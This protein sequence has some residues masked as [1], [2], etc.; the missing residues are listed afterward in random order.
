MRP[1]GTRPLTSGS[2]ESTRWSLGKV[3]RW[4]YSLV[5]G[6][7][8]TALLALTATGLAGALWPD[9][10]LVNHFRPFLFAAALAGILGALF[11][12]PSWRSPLAV[13][14]AVSLVVQGAFLLPTYAARA[15]YAAAVEGQPLSLVT[16]NLHYINPDMGPTVDYL[17]RVEP[18]FVFLQ[19]VAPAALAQLHDGLSDLL[20]HGVHCVERRYCNL[21]I[22]SR[23]PLTGASASYLGWRAKPVATDLALGN[24]RLAVDE[25]PD[26]ERAAAGLSVAA[27]LGGPQPLRLLNV[28]LTWPY[29]AAMQRR[30]FRW[31]ADR[32]ADLPEG[33][34]VLAGDF[35]ATPWSYGLSGFDAS[36]A[37]ERITRGQYSWPTESRFPMPLVPIDQVY[38]S[39]ELALREVVRGPYVGSDHY[40]I[41]AHLVLPARASQE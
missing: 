14:G 8:L 6:L 35:N 36:V 15:S 13:L 2:Q 25:L 29:P 22:L 20:P 9:L 16:L 19:E 28:H 17:R 31:V 12:M 34:R 11:A 33:P 4:T 23:T 1:G 37:M 24:W 32:A 27:D 38:I 26:R 3:C 40:P 39:A 30:Q 5:L 7:A 10:D 41:E 21:A 18:D